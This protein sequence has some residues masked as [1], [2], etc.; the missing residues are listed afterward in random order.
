VQHLRFPAVLVACAL[1][2][3][4]CGGAKPDPVTPTAA[5]SPAT[6]GSREVLPFIHDDYPRA[7]AE[8]KQRSKP[9]FV[10]AWA[11]WCHSCQSLRTF[12]L[13]DPVLAPL[14]S[15][16]VW[17]SVDTEKDVNAEWVS[18]HPHSALPT[19][20]VIDP[21]T[22]RPILKWAGTVTADELLGLLS[23]A[24]SDAKT[25]DSPAMAATAAFVRGNRAL[26]AG[27]TAAAERE[28]RAALA[29]APKDHPQ[30]ARIVE[31][32]VTMLSVR[33]DRRA[34]AELAAAEAGTLPPGTSRASTVVAGLGCAR[35]AKL[36][37]ERERLS[38][39]ALR[40]ASARDA[41]LLPDDRSAIYEQLIEEAKARGDAAG[42]VALA[43]Q[44]ASFLDAEAARA[45]TK[46]ARASLDPWRLSAYLALGEPAR[47][48][49]ILEQSERD[50]PEDYNPAA[51]LGRAYLEM[52]RLD[53]ADKAADRAIAL[54]YGPRAMRVFELKA[55]IA[56]A[57]GDRA[58]EISALER[59]LARSERAVLTEGQKSVRAAIVKRL[60]ALR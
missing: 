12:V 34:C 21:A 30:R 25:A 20:W 31:A 54:V 57:R 8:A 14:A 5:A 51:R 2:L 28:H 48:V 56:K 45:A 37:S 26:A 44:W 6:P 9:L 49:P 1:G 40:D 19:L 43:G 29:A 35:E 27:D 10:D 15:Q 32:L 3:V 60:N 13:T 50:F 52:K 22:D 17:L 7:L 23:V 24:V 47:A 46:D 38:E 36:G 41:A 39:V 16:F 11:T 42:A 53:E 59:A 18:R 55:N 4:A 58:A 33:E